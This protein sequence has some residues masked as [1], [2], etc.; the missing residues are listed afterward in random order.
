MENRRKP[1]P[2]AIQHRITK[3]FVTNLPEGC[4]GSDLASHVRVFGQIFDLYIA[5]KRDKRGNRFGFLSMLDVKD[6]SELLRNLRNIRMGNN[7]LWFNVA[8]FVLEDGEVNMPRD[9]PP[10]K[11]AVN[12]NFK[13]GMAH[14]GSKFESGEM[15]FKDM[16]VGKTV[17]IVDQ[18]NGFSSLHDRAIVGRMVDVEAMKSIYLFLHEIC[19][20]F[21]NV[22]YM[23]GLDLLIS[24]NEPEKALLVLEAAKK[25]DAL[26]SSVC[27]WKGQSFSFERLAWIK[28]K[29]IPL[30]LFTNDVLNLVGGMFGKVVYKA[31]KVESDLDLSFDYVGILVGDGRKL[32]KELILEWKS[33]KFRVWINEEMGDWIPDFYPVLSNANQQTNA[34]QFDENQETNDDQ[35]IE[36]S[37]GKMFVEETP[38]VVPEPFSGEE[39]NCNDNDVCLERNDDNINFGINC[40]SSPI[41]E[42]VISDFVPAVNFNF[43]QPIIEDP[44]TDGNSKV[45]KRKKCKKSEVG[46][47]SMTYTSSNE[48]Q[49]IV[50]KPKKKNS[51]IFGLNG[52]LGISDNN[53]SSDEDCTED[54]QD[55]SFDLN[56]N[57]SEAENFDQI[58]P[59]VSPSKQGEAMSDNS[60]GDI[61]A[62]VKFLQQKEAEATKSMGIKLGVNM[63][64]Q[65]KLILD[66]IIDEGLQKGNK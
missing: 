3:I 36:D 57:P 41:I 19:P 48:S 55:N 2:E 63:E 7:K 5:R 10:V 60:E 15:S 33:R 49:R 11:K 28:V 9:D 44:T 1:I 40:H 24:F 43:E 45:V 32:S 13:N 17:N 56:C 61:D 37:N 58:L 50:K 29:G 18:V 14:Q 39:V 35:N 51:D 59:N 12:T 66:S 34:K 27:L 25:D 38:E 21:G 47:P 4:S 30:H 6:C 53:P 16:L 65:D 64:Q 31:S 8:R 46:R 22:Q 42:E 54:D 26:F 52:L 62:R 23:G 20:G